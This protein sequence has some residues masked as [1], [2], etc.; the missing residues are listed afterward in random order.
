MACSVYAFDAYGTLF[1][2][3]AAVGR[4]RDEIGTQAQALS[5]LWRSKQLEYTW[6]RT[7]TGSYRDFAAV[8]AEAL[9]FAAARFGGI[10][11]DTRAKLLA[12]YEQLDAFAD[13]KACLEA[14]RAR[15][16]KTAIL[17]NGTPAMLASAA[18]AAGISNLLD[19]TLSV[20]TLGFYKARPEVYELV[21]QHFDV[22]PEAV[23]FQ[24]SNRWDVAAGA[25][26]GF[27][28]VWINRTGQPDEYSDM[29]PARVLSSLAPLAQLDG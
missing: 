22:T 14:L 9:D 15:G 13:V 5:D 26:F 11:A 4:Y 10:S 16:C 21:T 6:I 20:D 12:A 7:M 27:R 2:V 28:T 17:S 23:S 18:G 8:T 24:S 1:D 29:A 3:H 25:R 19:A